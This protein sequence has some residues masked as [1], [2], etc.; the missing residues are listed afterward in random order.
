MK[1]LFA[2][3]LCLAISAFA[4]NQ[5]TANN[6]SNRYG[7]RERTEANDAA[8]FDDIPD[9]IWTTLQEKLQSDSD[10]VFWG[11]AQSSEVLA[12]AGEDIYWADTISSE[13]SVAFAGFFS[14]AQK[15]LESKKDSVPE[16]LQ[17]RIDEAQLSSSFGLLK[18]DYLVKK[19][20]DR[21]NRSWVNPAENQKRLA[22]KFFIKNNSFVQTNPPRMFR[23]RF[24]INQSGKADYLYERIYFKSGYSV[25]V[26]SAQL[27]S[28]DT[29]ASKPKTFIPNGYVVELH[30]DMSAEYKQFI[31][32][33]LTEGN[34]EAAR[35]YTAMLDTF[36]VQ[37]DGMYFDRR[38]SS[39]SCKTKQLMSVYLGTF[40][41]QLDCSDALTNIDSDERIIYTLLAD[42]VKAMRRSGELEKALSE[43]SSGDRAFWLALVATLFTEDQNELNAIVKDASRKILK[44]EQKEFLYRNY[45]KEITTSD[46][47]AEILFGGGM[48][49]A[50]S[51][52]ANY[53][54]VKP[55]FA[56][57]LEFFYKNFGGGYVGRTFV[58]KKDD[59]GNFLSAFLTDLYFGYTTFKSAHFE[60]RVFIGP[61]LTFT[62][63]INDDSDDG[64]ID[65]DFNCGI[66]IGTAF[67]FYPTA[68]N[69]EKI[70]STGLRFGFRLQTSISSYATDL[71][72]D[73]NGIS[74]NISLGLLM[75]AYETHMKEYGE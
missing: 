32:D 61:T 54:K 9:S 68:P 39:M 40:E 17:Q 24:L 22:R 34:K 69:Q 10:L 14:Q 30:K 26:D 66:H 64:P 4:Y 12:Y 31:R 50:A 44:P 5:S 49:A 55:S 33:A 71:V 23:N 47:T 53:F 7:L 35:Y 21:K 58:S 60:N 2:I 46:W 67:D 25:I 75:Q 36:L 51:D 43:R 8:F 62:D 6:Q 41:D 1:R 45:A 11:V 42:S 70:S 73:G 59:D 19:I 15:D 72:K 38:P 27:A 3:V 57:S 48:Q 20:Y 74:F 28:L 37:G 56:V 18:I 29:L 13:D 63:L 16:D 52:A 65:T